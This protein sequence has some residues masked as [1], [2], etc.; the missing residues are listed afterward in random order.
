M[1]IDWD[2]VIKIAIP[3]A[4]LVL[5]KYLDQLLAKRPK[6]I[7]YLG[8]VSSFTMHDENRTQVHTHAIVVRNAGRQSANS[9]RIGHH[10][11][12]DYQLFPAVQHKVEEVPRGGPEILIEK[13]VPGEQVTVSYLYFPPLTWDRVNA[14]TKS[15]EGLA[16]I[17]TVI[18]S[19]QPQ[20]WVIRSLWVL[21]AI[22]VMTTLYLC[23]QFLRWILA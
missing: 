12:P 2:L 17:L 21:V 6:L 16:R 15:D 23:V 9:V 7:S 4:T 10:V 13:L 18:P 14:Y 22:G 20:P 8:H 1:Q 5:G 19:P 3:L 11:L